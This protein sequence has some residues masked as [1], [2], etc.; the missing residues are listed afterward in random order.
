MAQISGFHHVTLPARDLDRSGDWY[1][2]V[3]GFQR[4]LIEEDE[5]RVTMVLLEHPE[6][7]LLCLHQPLGPSPAWH[8]LGSAVAMLSFRVA[9]RADLVRWDGRLTE[10]GA[11]HSSP[12]QAHLGWALDVIDPS[13]LR[14][15]LHTFEAVSADDT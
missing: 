2:R 6:G 11:E 12:R 1:E 4:V 15:Q 7:M 3:F 13:G 14:V 8:G 10:L 9:S 5:D